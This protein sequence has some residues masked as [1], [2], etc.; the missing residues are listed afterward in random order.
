[1]FFARPSDSFVFNQRIYFIYFCAKTN[2]F[3]P[4]LL[5]FLRPETKPSLSS[6]F[7]NFRTFP[8]SFHSQRSDN[9]MYVRKFELVVDLEV[10]WS[11]PARWWQLFSPRSLVTLRYTW[12]ISWDTGFLLCYFSTSCHH[13]LESPGWYYVVVMVLL[14]FGF[15]RL[16]DKRRHL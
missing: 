3:I 2:L 15:S 9:I 13:P 7:R 8:E 4:K 11:V 14:H 6:L 10:G 5:N 12:S 1:M 16:R